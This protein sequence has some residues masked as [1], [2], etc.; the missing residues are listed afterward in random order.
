MAATA[1]FLVEIGTEELPPKALKKLMQAFSSGFSDGLDKTGL[2]HGEIKPYAAP[3]RLALLVKDVSTHQ[4]D[5]ETIRRGPALTAAFKEDGCPT[6][7]AQGFARSCGVEV[8]DLDRME[9]DKGAWLSFTLKESGRPAVDVLPS[10]VEAALNK[11]PVPKRMRWADLDVEFVRPVHWLIMLLGNDVIETELL[12]VKAGRETF[13]HRFHHPQALFIGEPKAYAPLL[14]TEGHV[15]AD[16][17]QRRE[18]VRAQIL[19]AA[20][21]AGASAV[22]DDDL[23]DEVTSMVEWPR[24]VAGKFDEAFLEVPAEAL[25]SAMK[26][27]QKYFHMVDSSGKLIPGFITIANIDSADLEQVRL[28]NERVIRPR[29]ADAAFFW[30]QDKKM[31][32]IERVPRLKEVVFQNK[33]GSIHDKCQRLGTTAAWVAEKLGV[34]KALAQQAALLCKTDLLTEMVGE[35]PDLQGTMGRYYAQLDGEPDAV[36]RALEEHY[37][38]RFAGDGLPQSGLGQVLS[39]ADKIDTVV[40]IFGIGQTP[41]GDKDP[42]GLRRAALGVLRILIEQKLDLDLYSLLA[43]SVESFAGRLTQKNIAEQVFHFMMERLRTYYEDLGVAP[44]CFESVLAQT[45]HS[46]YDFDLR[47]HAVNRFVELPEA[48]SLAAANKRISNILVKQANGIELPEVVD[49]ALFDSAAEA[50]L[51]PKIV[52]L[53]QELEPLFSRKD[54]V[55][56]LTA[57]AALRDSVDEFFDKV[58]VM[59]DDEAVRLNRLALLNTLRRQFLHVADLSRLQR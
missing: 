51:W 26:L 30:K 21:E 22:I 45:P 5:R 1:D 33:L 36:A 32:L 50:E 54:Y 37:Q 57:L 28:G 55:T 43:I 8:E 4:Q 3:R 16:F 27:H 38:P 59:V 23:L 15:V 18:A 42:F 34:D 48:A 56:A 29:L 7:A 10:L 11:L 2:S 9:S 20:S 52:G 40:G 58:M 12:S 53:S 25:I 31:K 46:P 49:E 35:F 41:S 14:E 13:G 6:P 17:A 44:D 47:I 39:I 19:E 24:A